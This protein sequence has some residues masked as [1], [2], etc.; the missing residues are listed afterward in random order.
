MANNKS[1]WHR[2]RLILLPINACLAWIGLMTVSE[3]RMVKERRTSESAPPRSATCSCD[4]SVPRSMDSVLRVASTEGLKGELMGRNGTG[5]CRYLDQGDGGIMSVNSYW[6]RELSKIKRA[7]LHSPANDPFGKETDRLLS[8]TELVLRFLTPNVLHR[9]IRPLSPSSPFHHRR[10]GRIIQILVERYENPEAANKLQVLVFGGSPITGSNCDRN[11]RFK[12]GPCAWPGHLQDFANAFLGADLVDVTNYAIGASNS[13]LGLHIL[14]QG[15][16]PDSM[17]ED[18]PDV[19]IYA[20]AVNDFG[21]DKTKH[22]ELFTA[23]CQRVHSYFRSCNGDHPLLIYLDDR[24]NNF[25]RPYTLE[26]SEDRSAAIN[27]LAE[28]YNIMTIGYAS[29][30]KDLVFR[31]TEA[32]VA[33]TDA[34]NDDRHLPW[35]GHVAVVLTIA[36]NAL[37]TFTQYCETEDTAEQEEMSSAITVGNNQ[38]EVDLDEI[39]RPPPHTV[40]IFDVTSKWRDNQAAFDCHALDRRPKCSFIYIANYRET[41]VFLQSAIVSATGWELVNK[42]PP[43]ACGLFA[44]QKDGVI[45]VKISTPLDQSAF[46]VRFTYLK[47]YSEQW[48]ESRAAIRVFVG[49]N[50][51]STAAEFPDEASVASLELSGYHDKPTSEY[52]LDEI[53]FSTASVSTLALANAT[54]VV[55]L[56]IAL[57]GG[58]TF[59]IG[60]LSLCSAEH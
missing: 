49:N 32:E 50:S 16:L 7:L 17:K 43:T 5:V 37:Y 38:T 40:S 12:S 1:T 19:V 55:Y 30:V 45:I 24:V 22:M 56:K 9:S 39:F 47:S 11:K 60:G 4:D 31:N 34:N 36:Y 8:M 3:L 58:G 44:T 23:F 28:W 18:G 33:L 21:L 25:Y 48:V 35:S 57:V 52:Y 41:S 59:R 29:M 26:V 10:V 54:A 15:Q 13:E 53:G 46:R 14:D 42:Y 51:T 27:Q 2:A 6:K 20:Y